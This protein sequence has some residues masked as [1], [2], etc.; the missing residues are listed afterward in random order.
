LA[1][2][3]AVAGAQSAGR[4]RPGD[5]PRRA[6]F[7]RGLRAHRRRA[8]HRDALS[9][10]IHLRDRLRLAVAQSGAGFGSLTPDGAGADRLHARATWHRA[11]QRGEE[12][13][14]SRAGDFILRRRGGTGWHWTDAFT[15][16]W[17]IGG[18]ILMF[19]P[20][21]WLVNSSFKTPAALAEFPPT[22]LP[23]VSAETTVEGYDKPLPLYEVTDPDGTVR[24][25]AEVRRI[26]IVAQMVDPEAPGEIVKVNIN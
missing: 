7:R 1:H 10:A 16:F 12:Q 6:D 21:L 5:D 18:F 14:M 20:A 9:H 11:P 3:A 26:G 23:Y 2:H 4:D 24:V 13:A 19:G 25:L 8:G 15:W 22:I 17:L